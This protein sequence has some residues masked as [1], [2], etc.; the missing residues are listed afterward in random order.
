ML[1]I[2]IFTSTV[3]LAMACG[4]TL[5]SAQTHTDQVASGISTVRSEPSSAAPKKPEN[6]YSDQMKSQAKQ[7]YKTG[8]KYGRAKLF[9]QAAAN[10]LLAIR[11]KPDYGD[12]YYGLGHAYFDLKRWKTSIAAL[13]QA[14][15]INPKDD[16]AYAMLG[17]AYLN[18]RREGSD[19]ALVEPP[20]GQKVALDVSSVNGTSQPATVPSN[21]MA[22]NIYHVGAGDV[23]DVRFQNVQ[24]DEQTLFTV[25]PTGLLEHPLLTEPLN[26]VG[27]T[28]DEIGSR[29]ELD[30]KR[31]AVHENPHVLVGVR[32]YSSHAVLISGLV[33]EPGT[34]VLRREAIPLYVVIAD[35]QP[36]PD[37]G[38]A[39][40][41]SH[42]KGEPIFV[43]L[44]DSKGMDLLV[45]PGNVITL[46]RNPVQ[47]FYIGGEV[48]VP[49]E[50]PYRPHLT[51][52]QAILSAG[53]VNKKGLKAE[54]AREGAPG[55]LGITKYKLKE[56][57]A[58]RWPDPE[59][60]PGDRIMVNH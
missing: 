18:L 51:L 3:V 30:L 29:I 54:L 16:E 49:G 50:K 26:V 7:Y 21:N 5:S 17:K 37:A 15:K 13:E 39:V 22:T 11:L 52:T 47:F 4:V 60:F 58:G 48:K 24:N 38:R 41:K 10:F 35:A 25:S 33:K 19:G 44:T 34:K 8:V 36:L 6:K 57:Y 45:Y 40:V 2:I 9:E 53:G 12:A 56:I 43:D 46:E 59:V 28:T 55:I 14:V 1:R 20:E 23:L 27:L 42:Q 31:R 32:E